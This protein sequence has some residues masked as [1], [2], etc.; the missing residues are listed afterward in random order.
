MYCVG[1]IGDAFSTRLLSKAKQDNDEITVTHA[2][3]GME[4][5]TSSDQFNLK[6]LEHFLETRHLIIR[7]GSWRTRMPT[8]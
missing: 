6:L 5:G 3:W 8:Q 1:G 4:D 7:G 2:W